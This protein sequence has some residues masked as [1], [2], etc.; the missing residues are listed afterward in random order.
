M[1]LLARF[2]RELGLLDL[3]FQLGELVATVLVA[4]LLLDRLHLLVEVV[5]ALGLL[6][7]PLDAGADA[8]FHLQDRDLALHQAEHLLQALGD[9][10]G[11]EDALL[12]RDLDGEMRGDGVGELGVVVDLLNDADDLRRHLLV[13]LHIALELGDDRAG[14]RLR[15]DLLAGVVGERDGVGFVVVGLF[16]VLDDTGALGALDQHLHGAV[17][18][19][20]E[21]Q[22][23]GER[24]D[25]EDG[26]GRR[27]I[28]GR[29]LLRRE[30]DERVGAH[31]LFEGADRFLAADEQRHDHV[32]KHHDVAQR[33]HRIGRV[34]AGG[35]QRSRLR[36]TC[37]GPIVLVV[38]PLRRPACGNRHKVRSAVTGKETW[39]RFLPAEPASTW[40][41]DPSPDGTSMVNAILVA[42]GPMPTFR[43]RR[44]P[45][46]SS[47]RP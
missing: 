20:E 41:R 17:G 43:W 3:V 23:A 28:V 29:I 34:F 9:G 21:L 47:N 18:Q 16:G 42:I 37:H 38:L 39:R 8:L 26:I 15:L 6:H 1:R 33:Q 13:E 35:R 31:H 2:L 36:G 19:L 22:H 12:V 46:L 25:L 5:L 24:T 40:G 14:E 11:L 27:I 45:A 30:Q 32:R 44:P 4:E 7:L 10:P